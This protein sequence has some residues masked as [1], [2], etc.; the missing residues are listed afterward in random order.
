MEVAFNQRF[1]DLLSQEKALATLESG[2]KMENSQ[3]NKFV[4]KFELLVLH[5][6]LNP[7]STL[8]L[9]KFTYGLP[10][11]MYESIYKL[12]PR[13]ITYKQWCDAALEQQKVW[14]HLKG[15]LDHFKMMNKPTKP[16]GMFRAPQTFFRTP[17]DPNTMDTSPR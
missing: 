9:H 5:A 6:G 15:L 7:D 14:V 3:L 13:P 12:Q 11:A 8:V 10:R 1:M 4:N 2:I 17:R 16:Q